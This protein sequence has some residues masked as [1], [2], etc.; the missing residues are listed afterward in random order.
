MRSRRG[1][2][3]AT[4][5][6]LSVACSSG[7]GGPTGPAPAIS[8][9][10]SPASV[11]LAQGQNGA[12]TVSVTRTNGFDGAV[13]LALEGAPQGVSAT[14][15]PAS[16]PAGS[17]SSTLTLAVTA[18]SA[19][20]TH[21][22]TVRATGS[23]LTAQT[24]GLALVVAPTPAFALAFEPQTL[25]A[26]RG[27]SATAQ[28][29][30]QRTHLTGA[31][32]LTVTGVPNG[33]T[34]RVSP[35][36]LT[37]AS[38]TLTVDVGDAAVPGTYTLTVTG[39]VDGLADRTAT[40]ALSI[41]AAAAVSIATP[42]DAMPVVGQPFAIDLDAAGE[43]PLTFE[44]AGDPLPD[45]LSL[46]ASTGKI[47]GTPTATALLSGSPLG[48]W[49]GIVVRV[50][51][52]TTDARTDPFTLTITGTTLPTPYAYMPFDGSD[53]GDTYGRAAI[54]VGNVM[55]GRE[56][57]VGEAVF[58]GGANSYVRYPTSLSSQL[59][60]KAA[61]TIATAIRTMSGG[62]MLFNLSDRYTH[63]SRAYMAL[64]GGRVR[65]GGR[66]RNSD[67]ESFRV[68]NGMQAVNDGEFHSV[69]GVMDLA[70][71]RISIYVDGRLDVT[72]AVPFVGSIF[73]SFTP[74]DQN[75]VGHITTIADTS[76]APDATH[77]EL[78]LWDVVLGEAQAATVAWLLRTGR[79][80]RE[81]IGF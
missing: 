63:W 8:I 44:S 28:V 74:A 60:G 21:T 16:V 70:S 64:D 27:T 46:D 23:G 79:P 24:A 29:A 72:T 66:S 35:T 36:A 19:T 65:L 43:G 81:W 54:A 68:V 42:D 67:T 55:T 12:I 56:G 26:G 75:V 61:F 47:G 22:L 32:A 11:S 13:T 37:G 40:L 49:N 53:L 2:A 38:A 33:V 17:T 25:Q 76:L 73:E 71:D 41:P 62:S 7:D 18:A 39:R 58:I 15:S 52:G 80:L 31:I 50:S 57:A 20:G 10:L 34:A 5:F 3:L 69:V 77:D 48:V 45:G 4:V 78:A 9:A 6:A 14:F 1:T 59:N 51:D 30:A